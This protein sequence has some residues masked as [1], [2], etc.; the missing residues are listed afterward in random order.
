M[1]CGLKISFDAEKAK[2]ATGGRR[3]NDA[4][5]GVDVDCRLLRRITLRETF[6]DALDGREVVGS[7]DV[8]DDL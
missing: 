2:R 1:D 3:E 8:E 5:A 7:R 4:P 6:D